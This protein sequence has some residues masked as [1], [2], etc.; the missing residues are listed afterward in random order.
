MMMECG[1][2]ACV[3]EDVSPSETDNSYTLGIHPPF[4]GAANVR[5][6][7]LTR[8]ITSITSLLHSWRTKMV[9]VSMEVAGVHWW[10]YVW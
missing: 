9:Q 5:Q 1:S 2:L 7:D 10:D 4:I 3:D 8:G 6:M